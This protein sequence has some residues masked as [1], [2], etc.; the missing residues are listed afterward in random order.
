MSYTS[1]QIFDKLRPNLTTAQVQAFYKLLEQ[2]ADINTVAEFV[3]LGAKEVVMTNEVS[4]GFKLSQRSLDRLQGVDPKMV[5]VVKRA[6][7]LT[8]IDFAITEGKRTK[9]RQAELVK[10]GLSQTMNSKHLDGSAVDIVSYVNGKVNWT[11]ENYIVIAEAFRKASIELG[12]KVRWGG[13][14][15]VLSETTSAKASY[16]A[17]VKQRKALGKKPFLDGVHFEI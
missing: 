12:I 17:Y 9:E 16:D 1:A 11:F 14:W 3:G 8:E 2:G 7:E 10:K 15:T 6:I 13:S 4:K 5:S